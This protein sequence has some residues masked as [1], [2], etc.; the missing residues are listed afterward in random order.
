MAFCLVSWVQILIYSRRWS[1]WLASI[2]GLGVAIAFAGAEAAL[3][4][5]L[6]PVYEAG[7][8]IAPL[9]VGIMANILLALGLLPPYGEILKRRGRVIGIN[10][11]FLSMDWL[12]SFFSLMAL[13]AQHTFDVLGGVIYIVCCLLELGIVISHLIWLFRT[14]GIRK[15]AA[16]AGKTFDDLAADYERQGLEFKFSERKSWKTRPMD[17]ESVAEGTETTLRSV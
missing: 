14:R 5:T 15:E 12:G 17:L 13:V 7:N 9:V 6:R 10:W 4:L 11:V 3:I 1:T 2:T 16:A 8:N